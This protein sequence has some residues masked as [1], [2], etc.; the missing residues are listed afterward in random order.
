MKKLL[1]IIP[2]IFFASL[3]SVL[4][5]TREIP[6]LKQLDKER[7]FRLPTRTSL[8]DKDKKDLF[9]QKQQF[10][11]E[12]G[13]QALEG[14]IDPSTYLVGPGDRFWITILSTLENSI[15]AQVSPEGKLVIQTVGTL[16]VNGKTLAEVQTLV[17][18]EASAKYRNAVISVHLAGVRQI[19]VHV[20]GQV[21]RPGPY[22][23]LAV[24]RVAD[25]IA[26]AG[27]LTSWA[28]ERGIQVRHLDGTTDT[29]DLYQYKKLGDLDANLVLRGGDLVHVPAINL[30][31][32]TVRVEGAINDPGTYQLAQNETIS[33]FLL[34]VDALTRR[35]DLANVYIER[36]RGTEGH[37]DIIA[38][39]P[40]LSGYGNGHSELALQ[41]GDVIMVPQRQEDVYVIGAVQYPGTYPYMPN[42]T[43]Q[44]YVGFAGGMFQAANPSKARVIRHDSKKEERGKD[45]PVGP[46][47]TVYVPKKVEFGVREVAMI[48]GQISSILI[49]LSAVGAFD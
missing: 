24:Y 41:D 6:Q 30:T 27:G 21:L 15:P 37:V 13:E 48:A 29:V 46:G 40:Y 20:T 39:F 35:A 10:P 34:R 16:D 36:R 3:A 18:Q 33:D 1:Q 14:A 25:I 4:A 45:K 5:Q 38:V 22:D 31:Q 8:L 44:D 12:G 49:A 43:V 17:A 26:L 19:R 23:A 7:D 11:F 42:S 47:D 28:F 9:K 32:A 2:V